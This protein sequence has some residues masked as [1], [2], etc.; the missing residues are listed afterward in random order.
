MKETT[1]ARSGSAPAIR[2]ATMEARAAARIA[3]RRRRI[4]LGAMLFPLLFLVVIAIGLVA[5][6]HGRVGMEFF[7]PAPSGDG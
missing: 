3:A 5:M 2:P 4:A 1:A 7:K 6:H